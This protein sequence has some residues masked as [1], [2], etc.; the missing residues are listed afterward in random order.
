MNKQFATV[1]AL[2]LALVSLL[3]GLA[4]ARLVAN[5]NQTLL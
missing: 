4:A 1:L 5:H 3:P 2:A